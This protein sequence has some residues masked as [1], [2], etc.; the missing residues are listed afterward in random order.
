MKVNL[1]KKN[2]LYFYGMC[3]I[4]GTST[5]YQNTQNLINTDH[6]MVVYLLI[7]FLFVLV[8]T[9]IYSFF[10][11]LSKFQSSSPQLFIH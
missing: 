9:P 4:V 5:E 10:V 6:S 8:L 11:S 3:A 2:Q 7:I 1:Q